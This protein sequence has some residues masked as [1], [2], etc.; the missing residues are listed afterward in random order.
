VEPATGA[1]GAGAH[2]EESRESFSVD[3][4]SRD[5]RRLLV[6]SK[7]GYYVID[8]AT[9]ARELVLPLDEKDEHHE[10]GEKDQGFDGLDNRR[11][12]TVQ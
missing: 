6:T 4:F 3:S 10:P 9:A 12:H 5:G 2:G 7:K 1:P 11:L 8:V